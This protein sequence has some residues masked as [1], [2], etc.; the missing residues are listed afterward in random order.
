M[1]RHDTP[2]LVRYLEHPSETA[3]RRNEG[4]GRTMPVHW[5]RTGGTD[6]FRKAQQNGANGGGG[7]GNGDKAGGGGGAADKP[8]GAAGRKGGEPNAALEEIHELVKV[9]HGVS[10]CGDPRARQG[11]SI[12]QLN[13]GR[14]RRDGV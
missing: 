14:W 8:G 4:M 1:T 5:C 2:W 9:C 11:A 7:G 12:D 3:G 13:D 6:T 10:W